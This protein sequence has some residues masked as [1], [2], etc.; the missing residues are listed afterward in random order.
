MAALYKNL[1]AIYEAM[2]QSFINYEEEY[3]FY[4]TLLTKY[5]CQSLLEMGC[6][7]GHLASRFIKNN[8]T[9]AG[10]DLSNDML[11][12]AKK[13]NPKAIFI[14]V[15]MQNFNLQ[16]KVDAGII[17]GRTISYLISNKDVLDTFT[18]IHKNLNAPGIVCF[19]CIDANKF[20]PLIDPAKTITHKANFE[21]KK[22]QRNSI[23]KNNF[24]DGFTFD[25][26]SVYYE[27][28]NSGELHK[29]GEDNS[30]IRAFT[31]DEIVLFLQLA[32]FKV[33]EI[34]K[35]PSYAFDTFV[36]VAQKN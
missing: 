17:T 24:K 8:F 15:E 19:D 28:N 29:I 34:I 27:E 25:W 31:K 30:T 4:S 7:T 1:T 23:W 26:A 35:R 33:K 2:Y 18:S 16:T 11:V 22:Y 12:I 6:G 21:N 9:Y 36:I 13:N 5:N 32:N 10:L 3:I 20:M 14:Q